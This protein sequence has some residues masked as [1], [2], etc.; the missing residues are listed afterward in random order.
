MEQ[1]LDL[2]IQKTYL[3]LEQAFEELLEEKRFEELTVNDL[4]Q[5]A[6]IRRTTF[7][8]HFGDKYEFF[9]FYI[10]EMVSTFRDQLPPDVVD[11]G[12]GEYFQQMGQEL[13]RFSH[14]HE[15]MVKNIEKSRM[16]PVLMSIFLE[17]ITEDVTMALGRL[18]P[19]L[20]QNP[21]K[22]K[23]VAAFY[24]GG[25]ISTFLYCTQQDSPQG[26]KIFLETAGEYAKQ[27]L[28]WDRKQQAL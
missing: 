23:V 13:V 19:R 20:A 9:A 14:I 2:R 21:G 4:C 6:L 25:L 16:F 18:D 1:K 17:E 28:A 22:L 26:E 27:M 8:K 24:A 11:G 10:R 12:A 15:K 3:S 7:Y 5:R